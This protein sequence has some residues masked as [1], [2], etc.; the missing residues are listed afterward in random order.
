MKLR[1][2]CAKKFYLTSN[3]IFNSL[4]SC[5]MKLKCVK[6]CNFLFQERKRN[7]F[8]Q[9]SAKFLKKCFTKNPNCNI[10][11]SF[12]GLETGKVGNSA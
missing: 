3:D 2:F 6:S 11:L 4:V 8:C 7:T 9:G 10:D 5:H 12:L 1:K